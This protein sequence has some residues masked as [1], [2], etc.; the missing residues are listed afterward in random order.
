MATAFPGVNKIRR[1]RTR[2][3]ATMKPAKEIHVGKPIAACQLMV[4]PSRRK[5]VTSKKPS[6]TRAG[7]SIIHRGACLRYGDTD[8][9]FPRQARQ[10][11]ESNAL[12]FSLG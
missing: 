9:V 5:L 12:L 7:R 2:L 10:V 8:D 3:S 1:P 4:L 6:P 11:V